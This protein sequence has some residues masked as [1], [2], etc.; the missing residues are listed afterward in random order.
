MIKKISL[1]LFLL[2]ISVYLIAAI[3]VLNVKPTK[4]VCKGIE[5]FITDNVDYGFVT[6]KDIT[7]L[8]EKE[9]KSPIGKKR[10]DINI[11]EIESSLNK[12]TLA[13][14]VECYF[15]PTGNIGIIVTQR[16]PLIRVMSN[17]GQNYYIDSNGE[18][19]PITNKTAYVAIATG[20]IDGNFAKKELFELGIFL[21]HNPMWKAQIEQINVTPTHELEIIPRV[22]NHV[23]F[24][25]KANNYDE[26]FKRLKIFYEKALNS[27]GWNKYNRISLEFSNQIICTKKDI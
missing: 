24:L 21:Q 6:R 11:R 27:I 19:M 18:F 13:E 14:Q 25:G 7:N 15:T 16:L 5:L 10:E 17:N 22:G 9:H 3:S 4:Q 8:L 26:K 23:I 1:L 20:F 2:L 12:L